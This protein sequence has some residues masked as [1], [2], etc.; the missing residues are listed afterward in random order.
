MGGF[1]RTVGIIDSKLTI[2]LILLILGQLANAQ[3]VGVG[4]VLPVAICVIF[5][6]RSL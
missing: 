3:V 4:V 2:L 6:H 5:S 1:Y